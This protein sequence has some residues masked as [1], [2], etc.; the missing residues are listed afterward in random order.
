MDWGMVATITTA[1]VI[2]YFIVAALDTLWKGSTVVPTLK[3][4]KDVQVLVVD[5]TNSIEKVELRLE[6]IANQ[7]NRLTSLDTD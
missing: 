5:L 6:E 4:E 3:W 7:L 1:A 2:A